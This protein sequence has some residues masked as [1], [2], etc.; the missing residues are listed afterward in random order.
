MGVDPGLSSDAP[1]YIMI[2][3]GSRWCPRRGPVVRSDSL[4][5]GKNAPAVALIRPGLWLQRLTT[6]EPDDAQITVAIRALSE[7][8]EMERR[9]GL[10]AVP[11]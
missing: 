3:R 10:P 5:P 6:R 7:A 8:L 1:F 2:S 4:E 11:A 9:G